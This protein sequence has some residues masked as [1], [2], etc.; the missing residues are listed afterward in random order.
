MNA[1][2]DSCTRAPRDVS[3]PPVP[4]MMEPAPPV[5]CLPQA[6]PW[7]ALPSRL[8]KLPLYLLYDLTVVSH[9]WTHSVFPS[10]CLFLVKERPTDAR[11][12]RSGDMVR[13]RSL[14]P[15]FSL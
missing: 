13:L 12:S 3:R 10:V 2:Q 9:W 15:L 11:K 4:S 7:S 6:E 14:I 5:P 1:R 8:S